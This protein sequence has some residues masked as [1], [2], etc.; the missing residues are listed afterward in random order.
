MAKVKQRVPKSAMVVVASMAMTLVGSALAS[1]IAASTGSTPWTMQLATHVENPGGKATPPGRP[2]HP[3]A[4]G[5][6]HL[7]PKVEAKAQPKANRLMNRGSTGSHK[8]CN[9]CSNNRSRGTWS[10]DRC[11][12]SPPGTQ[13]PWQHSTL[14]QKLAFAREEFTKD[15]GDVSTAHT[16]QTR[17][18]PHANG[19]PATHTRGSL[20]TLTTHSHTPLPPHQ[21]H[22]QPRG[23]LVIGTRTSTHGPPQ[24]PRTTTGA[25]PPAHEQ[26]VTT[27]CSYTILDL[28]G[29]R[30]SAH[31]GTQH[32]ST[33][34]RRSTEASLE[35]D[36]MHSPNTATSTS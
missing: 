22:P 36:N 1:R 30:T 27:L 15:P 16:P 6:V 5:S 12:R 19:Y 9:E 18:R 2:L 29:A 21:A 14:R 4:T 7:R 3:P 11:K 28:T 25:R 26:T 13:K 23:G 32:H 10:R 34:T 8:G 24:Q 20:T 33:A 31:V 35:L 17:A